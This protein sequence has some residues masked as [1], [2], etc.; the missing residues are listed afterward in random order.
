LCF[1]KECIEAYTFNSIEKKTH[2]FMPVFTPKTPLNPPLSRGEIEQIL[3]IIR[4][5]IEQIL[6][7]DKGELE[8]ISSVTFTT[9]EH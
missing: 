8:G 7:L 2:F 6:P 1:Q 3:P 9:Q 4:E 5:E